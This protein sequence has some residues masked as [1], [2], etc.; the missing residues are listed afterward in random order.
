MEYFVNKTGKPGVFSMCVA[1]HG[2]TLVLGVAEKSLVKKGGDF[3]Y[4]PLLD[5]SKTDKYMM[6]V[7]SHGKV[8]DKTVQL[9]ELA[10]GVWS[11]ATTSTAMGKVSFLA[12]L[13]ILME[14]YC[15]IP[16]LC[17]I[18]S[19]FRP[20][21]CHPIPDAD[22]KRMPSITF[23]LAENVPI[24]L[25]P[26]DYLLAYKTVDG[27]LYRCVAFIVTDLL[28]SIKVGIM[29]G[30]SVMQRHAV[31][32]DFTGRRIGIALAEQTMCGPTTGSDAGLSVAS[33]GLTVPQPHSVLTAQAAVAD[34]SKIDGPVLSQEFQ[35]AEECRAITDCS[36]CAENEKCSYYYPGGS[37]LSRV[38]A[39]GDDGGVIYPYCAGRSCMCVTVG[40]SGWYVGLIAGAILGLLCSFCCFCSYKRRKRKQRYHTIAPVESADNDFEDFGA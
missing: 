3:K 27:K 15:H 23:Y 30:A 6:A 22:L 8:G 2:G 28:S 13:E 1:R 24:T 18:N 33:L 10:A 14:H 26:E 17:T 37:C 40:V 32:F 29:F 25:E 5:V 38:R 35:A 20:Q 4:V 12:I 16:G 7:L 34:P 19:W 31:A 21:E 36:I 9:P 39:V 11:S